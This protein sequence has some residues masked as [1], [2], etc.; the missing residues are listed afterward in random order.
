MLDRVSS[1]FRKGNPAYCNK[2][3]R[4]DWAAFVNCFVDTLHADGAS[5]P[6]PASKIEPLTTFLPAAARLVAIGD[7]HGDMGKTRRAFRIGGL[8]DHQD[9]WSGG[10]ATAVQ[11]GDQLDR[12]DNE[13]QIL[14]F[15]ERLQKEAAAAGGALHILNGNH[16]TMNVGGRFRYA[17]TPGRI[18]FLRWQLVQSIGASMKAKC[19]CSD[20][21]KDMQASALQLPPNLMQAA[22]IARLAALQPGGHIA[23]RFFARHHTVLQI[24]STV[25]VHG[26][27]LPSHA[28]YGL[29]RINRESQQWISGQNPQQEPAFLGGRSAV[30]WA[31]EY[32]TEDA[33]RCDCS[34]LQ[35]ALGKIPGSKRM[36][37]GHTIQEQG[38]N[39][40]CAERVFRID[41]GMSKGCGNG[42]PEVL[43]IVNDSTVRR[44]HEPRAVNQGEPKAPDTPQGESTRG[45][46]L[47]PWPQDKQPQ[48]VAV[49]A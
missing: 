44:L 2:E 26:G 20:A 31:R 24:G 8:I 35:E 4:Q 19:G 39:S 45:P 9:R 46:D 10:T 27:I 23:Q 42:E 11:V 32:S 37:V 5:V 13:V 49:H 25:F 3:F 47:P 40:A 14:Y 34:A 41:V 18:D 12:G 6:A 30:V 15:L 43:E 17:T 38:I 48:P 21:D 1:W 7:L 36:V 22:N 28:D 33:R 29:E 16:E